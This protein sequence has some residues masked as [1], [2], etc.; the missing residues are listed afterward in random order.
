M[1]NV[2]LLSLY[3]NGR[4][5]RKLGPRNRSDMYARFGKTR[6]KFDAIGGSTSFR[7]ALSLRFAWAGLWTGLALAALLAGAQVMQAQKADK[8]PASETKVKA[9]NPLSALTGGRQPKEEQ[10]IAPLIP[11][12]P[13]PS[14]RAI[15]LTQVADSAEDL[16]HQ[17]AEISKQLTSGA[18]LL[19]EER[20]TRAQTEEIGQRATGVDEL[21]KGKLSGAELAD[22]ELYWRNP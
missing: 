7:H 16:D 1:N 12:G 6:L 4:F 22:E 17:L 20:D 21:L 5:C 13:P 10:S 15:P 3:L 19:N 2:N 11:V 14:E 8:A 9:T 18:D